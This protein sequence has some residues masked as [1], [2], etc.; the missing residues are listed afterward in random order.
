MITRMK[1]VALTHHVDKTATECDGASR[2]VHLALV[3]A[4][5]PHTVMVGTLSLIR[6]NALPIHYWIEAGAWLI[7]YRAQLWFGKNAPH[8]VFRRKSYPQ[9]SYNGTPT[10]FS[11]SG[12]VLLEKVLQ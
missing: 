6:R 1:L 4:N 10:E 11:L 9:W 3:R 2:L 5:I 7:D 12:C 8:G